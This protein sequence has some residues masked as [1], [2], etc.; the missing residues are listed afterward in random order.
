MSQQKLCT[1]CGYQG[2]PKTI[3]KGSMIVE[4]ALWICFLIPGLIYSIW[5]LSSRY[6]GCPQCE[7]PNMISLNSPIAQRILHQ[8]SIPSKTD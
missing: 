6:E 2:K 3:T 1:N 8:D 7:S 5:R 4:L